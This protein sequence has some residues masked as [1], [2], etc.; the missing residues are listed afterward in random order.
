MKNHTRRLVCTSLL[1]AVASSSAFAANI[2]WSGGSSAG[3]GWAVSPSNWSGGTAPGVGGGGTTNNTDTAT[4]N[5]AATTT[6][7]GA[8]T[9]DSGRNLKFINFDAGAGAYTL[10]GGSILLTSGGAIQ[11][12]N[13][14][15][16][17]STAE[18]INSPLTLEGGASFTN[19]AA[20][21]TD[22]LVFSSAA[23][24]GTAASSTLT[25][26]GS[27]T[28]TN[29]IGAAISGSGALVKSGTGNWIL[30]GNN[31]FTGSTAISSGT[32]TVS[33]ASG[34]LLATSGITISSGATLSIDDSGTPNT[35]RLGDSSNITMGNGSTFKYLGTDQMS[36]TSTETFG[37]VQLNSGFETITV[38]GQNGNQAVLTMTAS[39]TGTTTS[40]VG[41]TRA[42]NG[43][44]A[45]ING[46]NLGL[47]TG[48]AG[49][50]LI[51]ST[52]N[53][54]LIGTAAG[55]SSINTNVLNTKIVPYLLGESGMGATANGTETGV[56]NTF[57]TYSA[58]G[59]F[60][61][62]NPT[63]EF[64]NNAILAGDNTYI[65]SATAATGSTSI[66][67]LVI[68]GGN[69]NIANTGTVTN[70]SGALL[71]VTSNAI[72]GGT[73]N[74]GAA[75]QAMIVANP[76][77]NAVVGSALAGTGSL[78]LYTY[79]G[80][81]IDLT[82]TSTFSGITYLTTGAN[83][84][85]GG[86]G[87]FGTSILS[88]P[89]GLLSADN[90]AR[91]INNLYSVAGGGSSGVG[92]G[93]SN[94]FTLGA[95]ATGPAIALTAN[96]NAQFTVVNTAQTTVT[97][98]FSL[99]NA[100]TGTY[101]NN[102]EGVTLGAS[103]NL[104]ITGSITDNNSGNVTT[105]NGSLFDIT[106]KGAGANVTLNPTAANNGFGGTFANGF[107]VNSTNA[108]NTVTLGG[109]GGAGAVITP[110]GLSNFNTNVNGSNSGGVFLVGANDS[111]IIN[112]AFTFGG[113]TN[114]SNF[115]LGFA[116]SNSMTLGGAFGNPTAFENIAA[117]TAT[118]TFAGTQ[119]FGT[120]F[121]NGPGNT[122]FSSTSTQNGTNFAHNGSGTLVMAG[123]NNMTGTTTLNG[124]TTVLDY[125]TNSGTKISQNSTAGVA[126]AL[127]LQGVNIQMNA[128]SA[129]G[130]QG[131]GTPSSGANGTTLN[132]GLTT[133]SNIGTGTELL[134]TSSGTGSVTRNAG[135]Q[136]NVAAGSTAIANAN[137]SGGIIGAWRRW[138]ARTGQC[139]T[140]QRARSRPCRV[141]LPGPAR[142]R[143]RLRQ[144][145]S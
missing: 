24:I 11:I 140:A 48:S 93:G 56:A 8:V 21:S 6:T 115:A 132:Y 17:T 29:T 79:A 75:S 81:S 135:G 125:T 131:L 145:M 109:P 139:P 54:P 101:N 122:S 130:T 57:L 20:D 7:G 13:T 18:T 137:N 92:I 82:A 19:N 69:L 85:V 68:N 112:N 77:V 100:A 27:N 83:V 98:Q 107:V 50:L 36:T 80:G 142:A 33:G 84:L 14:F 138:A 38:D 25:L 22:A 66:N 30:Q 67:S 88:Q 127:N 90:Q 128:G 95:P 55:T 43:G 104:A 141:T 71:F 44:V 60:R 91:S 58:A 113:S 65:T 120:F 126:T 74:I 134:E 129:G 105:V 133:V 51:S 2:T 94:N 86:T 16:S 70:A 110:F 28:G 144:T 108:Y 5:T 72:S 49:D 46:T 89:S 23:T 103:A 1:A 76:N 41:F 3:S 9:V 87:V 73:Y 10:S 102:G 45:L 99:N 12:L 31:G 62:L 121:L 42:A 32:L 118:L 53:L 15:S 40:K 116:G 124:G 37:Q 111:Q 106:F 64:S 52:A 59:G 143:V 26:N 97:G 4:F 78:S 35:N 114:N 63:S 123:T 47:T 96:S 34:S 39:T 119:T 136:I 61:P 117:S